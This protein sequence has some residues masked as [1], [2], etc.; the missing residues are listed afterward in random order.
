[1]GQI[2]LRGN[3]YLRTL[4]IQGARSTLQA[5][6]NTQPSRASRLQRWIAE[7]PM[8][9]Q[10]ET[11]PNCAFLKHAQRVKNEKA[12]NVGTLLDFMGKSLQTE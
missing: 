3:V 9:I 6:I 12:L 2:S 1:L 7:A 10:I 11:K 4:L 8:A 5:A